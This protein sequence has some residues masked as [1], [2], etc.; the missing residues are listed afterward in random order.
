[1][2]WTHTRSRIAIIKK[3]DPTADVSDLRRQLKAERLEE[4]IRAVV[5]ATP[6]LTV[7][8]RVH[9]ATALLHRAGETA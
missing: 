3:N 2:G 4:H 1:M 7:E 6:P 5:D 8:Q 9:L